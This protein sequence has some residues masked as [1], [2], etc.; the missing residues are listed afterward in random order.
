L[1]STEKVSTEEDIK[2]INEAEKSL[3]SARE[4]YAAVN[5]RKNQNIN[6]KEYLAELISTFNASYEEFSQLNE[7]VEAVQGKKGR[8]FRLSGMCSRIIWSVFWNLPT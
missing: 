2:A 4:Y 8:R 7:L 3:E 6:S 1:E 5:E